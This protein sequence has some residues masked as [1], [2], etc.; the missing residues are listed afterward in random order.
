MWQVVEQASRFAHD[1]GPPIPIRSVFPPT[2]LP[3]EARSDRVDTEKCAAHLRTQL[4]ALRAAVNRM[5]RE[6]FRAAYG[7][8]QITYMLD[9]ILEADPHRPK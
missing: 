9:T 3:N 4:P 8:H 6:A 2:M 7:H 5:G 1:Y